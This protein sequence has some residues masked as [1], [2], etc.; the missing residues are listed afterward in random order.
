VAANYTSGAIAFV[1]AGYYIVS[2]TVHVP[3]NIRIVGEALA[4][5][6]LGTGT[7]FADINSPYPVVQV[8]APRSTGYV[9]MSDL[10]VSTQGG[11]A[12]AVLI[13]YNL[14]TPTNTA[15]EVGSPPS[16]LWD[17]HVRVGGFTGSELQAAQ[18]PKTP[19]VTTTVPNPRCVAGYL[20]MHVTRGA[21]NL[22]MENSWVW[23]ADHDIDD[24]AEVQ[25][26]I[27][28]GRGL[29]IDSLAGRIWL[30]ASSVEHHVLYQYQ[31][32]DTRDIWMG[33]IQTETPYFQ[34]NPPAPYPFVTR[35]VIRHDPDFASDCQ[36]VLHNKDD[37][38]GL[39][40][41]TTSRVLGLPG[42]PPC[43]MAWG[44][45][46][47][48]SRDVVILGAGLYSFFN[49][50]NN[51]CSSPDN[52]SNCQARILWA[53]LTPPADND[54]DSG[55]SSSLISLAVYNL[56]TVGSVSAVTRLGND[57]ALY[58]DGVA[59]FASTVALFKF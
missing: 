43:F 39:N 51:N 58:S 41:T 59:T 9:E 53:G 37:T 23:V 1:D 44:L 36:T 52:G 7:R 26:S 28:A 22:Y 57:V 35:D 13:E 3:P 32:V 6:I 16:G 47:L 55:A 46:V 33:Q 12:G 29:L 40:G 49:N 10:I 5:V 50:Y 14:N 34:P 48:G 20:S 54:G 15:C 27:F 42:N 17:V 4:S 2:D 30:V 21:G 56:D 19:G 24:L 45:R 11:T 8:G 25:I 18:C 38:S 31:L